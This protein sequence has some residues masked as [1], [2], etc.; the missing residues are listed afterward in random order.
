MNHAVNVVGYGTDAATKQ[1]YWLMRN[2]WGANWG[3][4]GYFRLLRDGK[5]GMGIC[6]MRQRA[7]VPQASTA[8]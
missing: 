4:K 8:F 6:G 3:E 2:S 1:N 5:P 7:Y